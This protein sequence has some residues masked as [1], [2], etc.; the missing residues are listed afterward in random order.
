MMSRR[1][2]ALR[3]VPDRISRSTP[4]CRRHFH[5]AYASARW[6]GTGPA[7]PIL[8]TQRPFRRPNDG[9]A[10]HS[11]RRT[12]RRRH[13]QAPQLYRVRGPVRGIARPGLRGSP[14]DDDLPKTPVIPDPVRR[15]TQIKGMR[16]FRPADAGAP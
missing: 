7:D 11:V 10:Q 5:I 9:A 13:T 3:E 16:Y 15:L 6:Y 12:W 4:A 8:A 2:H 14:V 1:A